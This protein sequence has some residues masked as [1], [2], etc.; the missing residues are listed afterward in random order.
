MLKKDFK[1]S[2]LRYLNANKIT[3]IILSLFL[4]IGITMLSVWGLN[5]N[6]EIS[7]YY[8]FS[9][10]VGEQQ[11]EKF[12]NDQREIAKIIDSRAGNF[13]TVSIYG[14]GDSKQYIVIDK[15]IKNSQNLL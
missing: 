5:G 14:E 6:F 1:Q 12:I 11:T 7:G 3:L 15:K 4:I 2:N 10:T 8:E 13:D 9:V